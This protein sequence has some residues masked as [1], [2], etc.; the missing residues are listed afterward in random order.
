MQ[1][2]C[3]EKILKW[4]NSWDLGKFR[5]FARSLHSAIMF[6]LLFLSLPEFWKGSLCW[7]LPFLHVF[8]T[9]SFFKLLQPPRPAGILLFILWGLCV[10]ASPTCPHFFYSPPSSLTILT[11]RSFFQFLKLPKPFPALR[12]LF[13]YTP[14]LLSWLGLSFLCSPLTS[15]SPS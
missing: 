12:F 15:G 8:T 6:E 9:Q 13:L 14:A 2:A 11:A 3:F 4:S 7:L 10:L 5:Q 1:N